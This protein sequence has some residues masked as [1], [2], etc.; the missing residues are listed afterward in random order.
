MLLLYSLGSKIRN[1]DRQH[2]M[3]GDNA[4]VENVDGAI[5]ERHKPAPIS[6]SGVV[7]SNVRK[8]R[9]IVTEAAET[10]G[11]RLTSWSTAPAHLIEGFVL[12]GASVHPNAVFPIETFRVDR[13]MSQL[14]HVSPSYGSE[15]IGAYARWSW[16]ECWNLIATPWAHW[17]R[18]REIKKAV[19][20]MEGFD[21]L[22]L[23]RMGI[24]HRSQIEHT[25]R[26]CRDC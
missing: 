25:V 11:P 8:S 3:S 7:S 22:T 21:D 2:A 10:D 18:E 6:H 4:R 17:R 19:V 5:V 26:Y 16:K 20:A 14:G 23:R 9:S 15:A 24:C 12:Y 13:N 1:S